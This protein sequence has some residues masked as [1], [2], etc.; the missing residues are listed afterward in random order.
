[1]PTNCIYV[2]HDSKERVTT[3]LAISK[4]LL[5]EHRHTELVCHKL[6]LWLFLM[7]ET[8]AVAMIQ[9]SKQHAT[10]QTVFFL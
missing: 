8:Q 5:L 7:V 3:S 9:L 4:Q 10:V 6:D 1:M 2:S